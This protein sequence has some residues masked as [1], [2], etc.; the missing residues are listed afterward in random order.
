MTC[1][2][3]SGGPMICNGK[4]YGVCS[5]FANYKHEENICGGPNMQSYHAFLHVYSK[6]INNIID[7]KK[8][9]KKNSGNLH[10]PLLTMHII[11]AILI[12]IVYCI[13]F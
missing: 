7:K 6:W 5:F 10:K 12:C 1:R 13:L 9:K 2:G 3:D 11:L 8:K 4:L